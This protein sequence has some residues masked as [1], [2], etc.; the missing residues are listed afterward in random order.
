MTG[1]PV[2]IVERGVLTASD[3]AWNLPSGVPR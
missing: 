3:E 1:E 2:E